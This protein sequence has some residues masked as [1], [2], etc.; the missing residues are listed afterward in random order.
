MTLGRKLVRDERERQ[1]QF[2][3]QQAK[4]ELRRYVDEVVFVVGKDSRD[5]V[6]RTQRFLRDEFASRAALSQRS[7]AQALEAVRQSARLPD[8]ERQ[9]RAQQLEQQW[10]DLEKVAGT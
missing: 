7:A 8:G 10:R 9:Q 5:A 2:R 4:Q 6:R 1:V 3:R